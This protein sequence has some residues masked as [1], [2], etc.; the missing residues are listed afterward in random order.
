MKKLEPCT[1][2]V[3]VKNGSAIEEKFGG[4]SKKVNIELPCDPA[5]PLLGTQL[6]ST[7]NRFLNKYT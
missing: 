3:G 2:L 5:I 1:V 7:E 6:K 4:S